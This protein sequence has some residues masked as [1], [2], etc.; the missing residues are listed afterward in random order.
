MAITDPLVLPSDILLM[1]VA[2]LPESVREKVDYK[3]GDFAVTRPHVRTPS[4]IVD[5]Q[6][7]ELLKEF[8][9]AKTIVEAILS[10]S[11]TKSADP[12]Q[13]LEEALPLLK[14]FI[15]SRLLVPPDSADAEPIT[16]SLSEGDTFDEFE[17]RSGVQIL[18]DSE[19]YQARYTQGEGKD[20]ALK[21]LR[22]SSRPHLSKAIEREAVVLK[23]LDGAVSPRL[24]KTGVSEGRPFLAIEWFNGVPVPVLANELNQLARNDVDATEAGEARARLHALVV[25]LLH[26]YAELHERGVIHSDV[27]PNNL[28]VDAAGEVKILD[29]GLARF[30]DDK[31]PFGVAERG[32]VGYYF[33]PEC[34][35]AV[36]SGRHEPQSSTLGEQ[37]AVAAIA[38]QLLTGAN[39]IEF[40]LRNDEM[41]RQIV[42][43]ETLPFSAH[44]LAAS[45]ELEQALRRALSKDPDSRFASMRD[46]AEAVRNAPLH[47]F[48][49]TGV[50]D[51]NQTPP[52]TGDW[53]RGESTS[54]SLPESYEVFIQKTL[55]RLRPEGELF[56]SEIGE[57]HLLPTCSVNYGA[58][59][60]AYALLRLA[61]NR[62][63][64][65]L[66][67]MADLWITKALSLANTESAFYNEKLELTK[68]NVSEVSMHHMVN[69]VHLVRALVSHA[70]ADPYK[71][72]GAIDSFVAT[73]QSESENLDITLGRSSV[74]H[75]CTLL[76][77]TAH[78]SRLLDH[79][80]LLQLG[81]NVMQ[82]IWDKVN[83]FGPVAE[84]TELS[85]LG[86]A[87]GWAGLVY[88]A[89]RWCQ[90]K[91]EVTG[92]NFSELVPG[93]VEKRLEELAQCALPIGRGVV[94]TWGNQTLG[95]VASGNNGFVPGWCNGSAGHVFLWT[96]AHKVWARPNHLDLARKAAWGLCDQTIHF[97]QLC[98][99]A[100]GCAYALLDLYRHT[101]EKD[102]F[103]RARQFGQR[104]ATTKEPAAAFETD[105]N[106]L[107]KG[108]I[109][110]MVLLD[111]L[112]RPA[113]ARMPLF[114]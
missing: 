79:T 41:L 94:W 53:A 55:Q 72:Q 108:D 73:S 105:V 37:Y 7:A 22:D 86:M 93:G 16:P 83:G 99:G 112:A 19:L 85:Y 25:S 6:A 84:S 82:S 100:G 46:F 45:P 12:R 98:C 3:E 28:L 104:V 61:C 66:L 101:E 75:G 96:L 58:A 114:D 74:L 44:G 36:V 88:A 92:A 103:A 64:P 47:T 111:D 15:D 11:E 52:A 60:I 21:L 20:V 35:Q 39:H 8:K 38:Y 49:A 32:G 77:E 18:E 56:K 62:D 2:D 67:S 68:E 17:I 51:K 13:A 9:N 89:L 107:Y 33:E 50:S 70:L 71:E 29:F 78:E 109:G 57:G 14:N 5:A 65:Q 80:P 81:D 110:T 97:N 4:K 27:H 26:K 31:H 87:H 106:S 43:A 63:D 23:H 54:N 42:E 1:P 10:Y 30:I 90:V 59:G 40:S 95:D 34:A 24:I 102:W 91:A 76:L 69:G 113:T 48:P